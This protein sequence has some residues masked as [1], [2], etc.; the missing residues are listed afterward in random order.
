MK[1][2]GASYAQMNSCK[3]CQVFLHDYLDQALSNTG[4]LHKFSNHKHVRENIHHLI[5][6]ILRSQQTINDWILKEMKGEYEM[7]TNLIQKPETKDQEYLLTYYILRSVAP[8]FKQKI[9]QIE[10]V[11][12]SFD[13]VKYKRTDRIYNKKDQFL[14]NLFIPLIQVLHEIHGDHVK[15]TLTLKQ[16]MLDEMD[17]L[18]T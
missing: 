11:V 9:Q 14:A 3:K 5:D 17:L 12:D 13:M 15:K 18:Y 10:E 4:S 2:K 6:S 8:G 1:V 16:Y 7:R